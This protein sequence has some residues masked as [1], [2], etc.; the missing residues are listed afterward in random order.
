MKEF[1][2]D[3][4]YISSSV[5]FTEANSQL[6]KYTFYANGR[7]AIHHLLTLKNWRRIW[8]PEYYCY[9]I[10]SVIRSTGINIILYPDAP[11]LKDNTIIENLPFQK[12]DVLLRMNFFGMRSYRD[13]RNVPIEVIEDHSHDFSGNW[14]SNSNADWCIASLRKT[15]PIPEGGALWSPKKHKMPDQPLQ[16]SENINL[17]QKRWLAMKLKQEYLFLNTG[18]KNSF[19][20]LFIETENSF[21][22]LPLSI[23]TQDCI[24]YLSK[25]NFHHWN[26]QKYKNWKVLAQIKSQQ[27]QIMLPESKD[28]NIFSFVFKL[29][30]E[31]ARCIVRSYLIKNNLYPAILWQI[32]IEKNKYVIDYSKTMLS[33][34]CDGRYNTDDMNEIKIKLENALQL[35]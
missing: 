27:L 25:F 8:I 11:G 35:V 26:Q 22:K 13:N 32:P 15:I 29:K 21:E 2:S 3:F 14:A 28:C 4:H 19:R 9:E 12:Y 5:F 10:I 6:N 33:I 24:E 17:V 34:A 16:T 23:L 7:Q 31:Q 1:G 30:S 20:E 18:N